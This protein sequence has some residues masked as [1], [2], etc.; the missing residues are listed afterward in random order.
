MLRTAT[1]LNVGGA[2]NRTPVR[3]IF[4]GWSYARIPESLRE[5]QPPGLQ[6][7]TSSPYHL[8]FIKAARL[9]MKSSRS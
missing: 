6:A 7:P 4:R 3:K 1:A 2:G 8:N 5:R 9:P